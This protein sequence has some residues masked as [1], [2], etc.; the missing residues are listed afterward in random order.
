[1]TNSTTTPAAPTITVRELDELDYL[2]KLRH[3]MRPD[4]WEPDG[5]RLY[6]KNPIIS[7]SAI[8]ML[9]GHV[10]SMQ[11]L[12]GRP[13]FGIATAFLRYK[14][15]TRFVK[16]RGRLPAGRC[17][18][19]C[20]AREACAS[21]VELRIRSSDSLTKAWTE[22]LQADG[23]AAFDMPNY[24]TSLAK[25][26]WQ[27]FCRDLARHPFL[28]S[29]DTA[30]ATYY[31]EQDA[32]RLEKDRNRQAIARKKARRE[33]VVDEVDLAMLENAAIARRLRITLA[34]LHPDSPIELNRLPEQSALELIDVW[35]GREVM[36]LRKMKLN[37]PNIARWIVETG[38]SNSSKNHASLSTRVVKD[39]KRIAEFELLPWD[40][41]VLL[42][43]LDETSELPAEV[44]GAISG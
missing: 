17:N 7:R 21:V 28:S 42:P 16:K 6:F 25:R 36:R 39:L 26:L 3:W 33:G 32:A 1:M 13:C 5:N 20:K 41:G 22:W 9:N 31:Q 29:N 44:S 12:V 15:H 37:A 8:I 43:P 2:A 10:Q 4:P 14:N 27:A 11:L 24:D 23:P 18:N 19:D 40:G 30:V 35:L 38:R 34:R